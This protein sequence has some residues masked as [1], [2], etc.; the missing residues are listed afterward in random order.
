MAGLSGTQ[1]RLACFRGS[2]SFL[3][4]PCGWLPRLSGAGRKE[5]VLP[6]AP[7]T[8]GFTEPSS[9]ECHFKG[10]HLDLSTFIQGRSKASHQGTLPESPGTGWAVRLAKERRPGSQ[11]TWIRMFWYKGN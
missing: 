10:C 7:P 6:A 9:R 8:L 5:A 3:I 2:H 11:R 4:E 1:A